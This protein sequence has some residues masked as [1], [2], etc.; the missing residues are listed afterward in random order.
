MW[1]GMAA[2]VSSRRSMVSFN[3]EFMA[4]NS[5]LHIKITPDKKLKDCCMYEPSRAN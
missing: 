5:R 3:V 4:E 2:V 1:F